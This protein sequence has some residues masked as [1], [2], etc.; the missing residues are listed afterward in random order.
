MPLFSLSLLMLLC[1]P[2]LSG[3]ACKLASILIYPS[4]SLIYVRYCVVLRNL[5]VMIG[6]QALWVGAYEPSRC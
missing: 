2:D 6:A 3:F 1:F 4:L 5:I